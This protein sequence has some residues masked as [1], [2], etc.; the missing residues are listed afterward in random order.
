MKL[1]ITAATP[2]EVGPLQGFLEKHFLHAGPQHYQ[3]GELKVVLL[4]TGVGAPLAIYHLTRQLGSTRFN[5]AINAGI[6]GAFRPEVPLGNVFRVIRDRFADLG[7]EERDGAFSDVFDMG[8][9]ASDAF[10]FND[11]WLDIS[12][13]HEYGFLPEA[14]GITVNRVH[15]A[16]DS[17]ARIRKKY[18][19]ADLESMEGAG[20]AYVCL[21]ERIPC[22]QI[23][24]VSNHVEPRN[25]ERWEIPLAI[26][27]LNEVL[28]ELVR[29]LAGNR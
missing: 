24:S 14:T 21:Q 1:L 23:R 8:L 4:I 10:P 6:A 18:P 2:F 16:G 25:R 27:R 22:L 20:F 13:G 17:I 26:D 9:L 19:E 11:G 15:G 12:G 5:L 29:Q 28:I 7:V 3:W